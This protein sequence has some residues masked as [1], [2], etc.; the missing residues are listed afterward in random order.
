MV[1]DFAIAHQPKSA[2]YA[3]KRLVAGMAGVDN[4]QAVK[5]EG[6]PAI[7]LDDFSGVRAA[8]LQTCERGFELGVRSGKT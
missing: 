4:G 1:V 3:V 7:K 2:V 8:V 6:H 5:G